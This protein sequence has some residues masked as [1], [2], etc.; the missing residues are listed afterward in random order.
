M[1]NLSGKTRP[2]P[3]KRIV[4]PD[5]MEIQLQTLGLQIWADPRPSASRFV[6]EVQTLVDKT[7]RLA[8]LYIWYLLDFLEI[9]DRESLILGAARRRNLRASA[10]RREMVKNAAKMLMKRYELSENPSWR[11]RGN[12]TFGHITN[13]RTPSKILEQLSPEIVSWAIS[14]MASWECD[15]FA[16]QVDRYADKQSVEWQR[17]RRAVLLGYAVAGN[18]TQFINYMTEKTPPLELLPDRLAAAVVQGKNEAIIGRFVAMC[19]DSAY[20][21]NKL[22]IMAEEAARLADRQCFATVLQKILQITD[23]D[24]CPVLQAAMLGALRNRSNNFLIVDRVV[25]LA[26]QY[27]IELRVL[28]LEGIVAEQEKLGRLWNRDLVDY[29]RSKL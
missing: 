26:T 22:L 20:G 16:E 2:D 18:S 29:A 27:D 25:E 5:H 24:V 13:G 28:L 15:T 8:E 21:L 14:D 7:S 10:Q 6:D 1:G 23:V 9:D 3:P 11:K 12:I 17:A 4:S 19:A